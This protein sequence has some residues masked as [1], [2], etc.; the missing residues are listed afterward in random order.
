M[1]RHLFVLLASVLSFPASAGETTEGAPSGWVLAGPGDTYKDYETALDGSVTHSGRISARVS[2]RVADPRREGTLM[3][4]IRADR[5]RGKRIRL[6]GFVQAKDVVNGAGLWMRTEREFEKPL[7]R[8]NMGNR[9]V[10]GTSGW[11]ACTIVLDVP[12][13]AERIFFGIYVNKG[14]V[15]ADDLKFEIVDASV[16]VTDM[17]K[18][19]KPQPLEPVNLDFMQR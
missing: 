12:Q 1:K 2:S 10:K 15:W 14:T 8:D 19:R 16:P 4:V 18:A 3:Q 5:Y 9:M 7:T 13:E 11:V 17:M 6:S